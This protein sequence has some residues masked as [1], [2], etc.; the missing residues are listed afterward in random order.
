ME[1][2]TQALIALNGLALPAWERR[3]AALGL[4]SHLR[5]RGQ[6]SV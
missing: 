5:P 6:L 3:L 4:S 1:S 2:G